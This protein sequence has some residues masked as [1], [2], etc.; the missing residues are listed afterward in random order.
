MKCSRCTLGRAWAVGAQSRYPATVAPEVHI[1]STGEEHAQYVTVD[2][3]PC[4]VGARH[5]YMSLVFRAYG[6]VCVP[7]AESHGKMSRVR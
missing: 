1:M 4:G 3:G 5:L 6:G 7:D 2:S